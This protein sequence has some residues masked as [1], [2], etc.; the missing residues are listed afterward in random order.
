MP[1]PSMSEQRILVVAQE[2]PD[3]DGLAS[4]L[5]DAGYQVGPIVGSQT[6]L[7]AARAMSPDLILVDAGLPGVDLATLCRQLA[8]TD[9]PPDAAV[10]LIAEPNEPLPPS[11]LPACGA[12]DYLSRPLQPGEVL[13]RVATQLQLLAACRELADRTAQLEREAA[14]HFEAEKQLRQSEERYRQLVENTSEVIYSVDR[15]GLLTYVSPAIKTLLGY[16]PPELVGRPMLQFVHAG[17]RQRLAQNLG[18]VLSGEAASN[19]YRLLTR[20]G[21]T[22]WVRTSSRPALEAGRVTG[23]F[24][25]VSDVTE[26]KL[27]AKQLQ[28]QN[29]FLVAVLES[30]TH[31]FYVIDADDL[32]LQVAN[33]AA[34]LAGLAQGATC[35]ALT[36][37]RAER[38]GQ[39]DH[40]CPVEEIKRTGKPTTVEH[41]H[42]DANGLERHVELRGYPLF[43]SQG[44]VARVIE[45]ALDV[46]ERRVAEEAR[47]KSERR[48]RQLLD[49]L[50]E[51]IWVI[52]R[53]ARTSFVNPRMAEMLGY[54]AEEMLS[55]HLFDFMDERGIE[56]ARRH[57]ERRTQGIQEQHDFELLTKDGR[58][59][60]TVMETSPI[61]DAQGNYNGA[62][63][64]VLDISERR[65][66]EQALRKSEA[67]LQETQ[68]M[69]HLGGW[70]LDLATQ[71]V[72]WTD[73]VYRIHEVPPGFRPTLENALGFYHPEDRQELEGAIERAAAHGEPW[74]LELRFRTAA[75][76]DRWVRADGRAEVGDGRVVRLSGTFQD[77]TDR[78][79]VE[80]AALR[81]KADAEKAKSQEEERRREAERRREIAEGLLGVMRALNSNQPLDQVL[82]I[83]AEQARRSLGDQSVA[84]YRLQT[85]DGTFELQAVAEPPNDAIGGKRP[86]LG[87]EALRE[88]VAT[89]RAVRCP[90]AVSPGQEAPGPPGAAEAQIGDRNCSEHRLNVLAAPILIKDEVYGAMMFY[91]PES[92]TLPIEEG[93]LAA[94]FCNQ[95]ALAIESARLREQAEEAA[96]TAERSRLARDLHDSVT[97]SLFSASLVAEVLAQVWRKNPEEAVRSLEHLRR[98]TRG[99]LAEM[100]ALLL[101]LRPT[102]LAQSRLEDLVRQLAEAL[103]GRA[104]VIVASDVQPVPALPPE[105]HVAFY[106]IAQEALQNIARHAEAG[107]VD[108]RLVATPVPAMGQTWEEWSGEVRLQVTDDG[109]GFDP[110]SVRANRL[111]LRIMRER[112]EG[113]GARFSVEARRGSGTQ[114]TLTWNTG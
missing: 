98:L 25:V 55:K 80:E 32:T 84:I 73:E 58:R 39:P 57:L 91:G 96:V 111:G 37:S 108:L 109:K 12:A 106:R 40:P 4:L 56:I 20:S 59:I 60:Y 78:K 9:A 22:R 102:A 63:A 95:A 31:P 67:L 75:G 53:D 77:I 13:T 94:A 110:A 17:D 47:A 76:R 92:R 16:E 34:R 68:R 28:Q 10:V 23:V 66:A 83:I 54:A 48:Y 41:I 74:N 1:H 7:E 36:H 26:G 79:S 19:E 97:Q 30:L 88:A 3:L 42:R 104:D 15:N 44:R 38:C 6:A 2:R 43:D 46:T 85:A 72:I 69:A 5:S 112:A 61:T 81:A 114:I 27:V 103:G 50:Q 64:G 65:Q 49:A 71:Q 105:V 45:Y 107:H 35:Y 24:G 100:R 70:E 11:M 14:R 21:D 113:I 62:V 89:R 93:D 52:D 87:Q 90:G 18:R 8:P 101:E 29:D 82:A 51:G 99:A 33:S 86:V